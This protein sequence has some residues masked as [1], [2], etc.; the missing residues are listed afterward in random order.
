LRYFDNYSP[1]SSVHEYISNLAKVDRKELTGS[2]LEKYD[3]QFGLLLGFPL[4]SVERFAKYN[5]VADSFL[6]QLASTKTEVPEEQ[7]LLDNYRKSTQ[8]AEGDNYIQRHQNKFQALISKY[9]PQVEKEMIEYIFSRRPSTLFGRRGVNF[10]LD[11]QSS[12]DE[13][14]CKKLDYIFNNS[15]INEYLASL[16]LIPKPGFWQK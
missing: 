3:I 15:G 12:S 9:F 16:Q 6:D 5:T 4:Q 11:T 8:K 13:D 2:S 14:Y 1:G 7:T 10:I